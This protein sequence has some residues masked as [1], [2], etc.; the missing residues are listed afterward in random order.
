MHTQHANEESTL[1][2]GVGSRARTRT[3]TPQLLSQGTHSPPPAPHLDK[4]A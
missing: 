4:L 3:Q 1:G 2:A